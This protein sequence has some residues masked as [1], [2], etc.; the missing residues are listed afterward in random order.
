M[1]KQNLRRDFFLII[2]MIHD[3]VKN[4]LDNEVS[5]QSIQKPEELF[6][7]IESISLQP[8]QKNESDSR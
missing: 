6:E 5:V 4:R 2:G 3:L 8:E 1:F 7:E